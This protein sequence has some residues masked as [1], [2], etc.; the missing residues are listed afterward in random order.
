MVKITPSNHKLALRAFSLITKKVKNI[1]EIS[2]YKS[3][4]KAKPSY[5]IFEYD[6]AIGIRSAAKFYKDK[7]IVIK[8]GL[9]YEEAF[10]VNYSE[11][12]GK[13]L[14]IKRTNKDWFEASF[15]ATTFGVSLLA[16]TFFIFLIPTNKMIGW[17]IL[18][19][20]VLLF[21]PSVLSL[22]KEEAVGFYDKQDKLVYVARITKS[23]RE[24][25][26]ETVQF[27]QSKIKSPLS[28]K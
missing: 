15:T 24:K 7:F 20:M 16:T 11:L 1:L 14:Q 21:L 6:I 19:F 12:N 4:P 23:N 13:I 26:G 18:G 27:I 9:S 8:Q 5:E 25:I 22:I 3:P 17:I 28:K 2:P 10:E